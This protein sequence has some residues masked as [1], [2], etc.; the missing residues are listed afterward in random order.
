MEADRDTLLSIAEIA[1]AFTG[2]AALAGVIGRRSLHR[3]SWIS[4]GLNPWSLRVCSSETL[5]WRPLRQAL[6]D[7]L[8]RSVICPVN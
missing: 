4:R 7:Y 3:N 5:T 8:R 6:Y 2:F 1:A